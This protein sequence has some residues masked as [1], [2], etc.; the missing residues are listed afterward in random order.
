MRSIRGWTVTFLQSVCEY[1]LQYQNWV[2]RDTKLIRRESKETWSY[3]L[4]SNEFL[5]YT[6]RWP[7]GRDEARYL[8][9]FIWQI[10]DVSGESGR[11]V[12]TLLAGQG[13][14][15]AYL[16]HAG[17]P[18]TSCWS[19]IVCLCFW[20][21][22][23]K[24]VERFPWLACWRVESY[25]N[26]LSFCFLFCFPVNAEGWEGKKAHRKHLQNLSAPYQPVDKPTKSDDNPWRRS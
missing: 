16:H 3:H 24:R 18:K 5:H 19:C 23:D 20:A 10:L 21:V 4:E 26:M 1:Y 7:G 15:P 14:Q 22:R 12:E 9:L 13:A 2:C 6:A 8:A 17:V 11:S 25:C